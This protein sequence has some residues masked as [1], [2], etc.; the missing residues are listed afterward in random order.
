MKLVHKE[1]FF[2]P[3]FVSLG[4]LCIEVAPTSKTAFLSEELCI[5]CGICVKV[6]TR[7]LY[8]FTL[9]EFVSL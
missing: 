5:G 2:M 9:I 6:L 1:G 8:I 7:W 3:Y 4:R